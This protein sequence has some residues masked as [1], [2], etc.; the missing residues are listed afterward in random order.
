VNQSGSVR[1]SAEEVRGPP[2]AQ[3]VD[4]KGIVDP[5]ARA[6][7]QGV[8]GS[9]P[10]GRANQIKGLGHFGLTLLL[11]RFGTFRDFVPLRH[12]AFFFGDGA[13]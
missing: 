5:K 9:N 10:A 12:R 3:V 1:L 13:R 2:Q 4:N 7:N 8:V 6:T 11:W